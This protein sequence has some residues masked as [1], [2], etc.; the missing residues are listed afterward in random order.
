MTKLKISE[1]E[2]T[3]NQFEILQEEKKFYESLYKSQNSETR[4]T[5]NSTFLDA[6]NI[7]PLNDEENRLCEGLVSEKECLSALKDFKNG[8]SPGTDGLTAEFYKYFWSELRTDKTASF[9]YAFKTG[10]LSI[11]QRRGIISLIPKKNQEKS[12]IENLRPI[13]LLSTDYYIK[14]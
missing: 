1:N 5:S 12:L 6:K 10:T 2:Y 14:F 7:T 9:N 11:S 3:F 8:K 13:S 4:N